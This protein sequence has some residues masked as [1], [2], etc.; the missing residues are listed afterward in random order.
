MTPDPVPDALVPITLDPAASPAPDPAAEPEGFLVAADDGTRIHFHDWSVSAPGEPG[1]GAWSWS[2]GSSGPR[3]PGR[4]SRAACRE[5]GRRWW[6]TCGAMGCR[7]RH[8]RLRPRHARRRRGRGRRGLGRARRRDG[9]ARGSRVRRHRGG[10]G[11]RAPGRTLRGPR[12]GGRRLGAGRGDIRRRRRRVPARPRRAARGAAV[13]GCLAGGPEGLRPGELGRRPGAGGA[14]RGRGDRSGAP[15]A[16][17]PAARGGGGRPHHVRVR[18]RRGA[19]PV[20]RPRDGARGAGDP[21]TRTCAS[22][23]CGVRRRRA[24]RRAGVRSGSPVSRPTPTT[25]SAIDPRRSAPRSSRLRALPS[26]DHDREARA[27]VT[28]PAGERPPHRGRDRERDRRGGRCRTRTGPR[29][30]RRV[31]RRHRGRGAPDP[32]RDRRGSRR[33]RACSP[34]RTGCTG[35]TTS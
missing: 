34:P 30:R 20:E 9:G 27:P 32:A 33:A 2:R 10:R 5:P 28:R 8:R 21:A 15:A 29:A 14:G 12:A 13:D 6:R 18:A 3:G 26:P 7:T 31:E 17:G 23:S 19:C 11:R 24:W 16:I 1:A 25:S 22:P 4:R 35:C